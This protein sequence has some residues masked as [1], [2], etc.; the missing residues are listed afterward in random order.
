[1]PK[2]RK[3][4]KIKTKVSQ[5]TAPTS[6]ESIIS[7]MELSNFMN[8]VVGILGEI[9]ENQKVL[10]DLTLRDEVK[11]L[12]DKTSDEK[13][14]KKD[15]KKDDPDPDP[16]PD[17]ELSKLRK[18]F[19]DSFD[20]VRNFLSPGGL[21]KSFGLVSG[22]PIFML[23]GEKFDGLMDYYQ[24][25]KEEE[26]KKQEE[27]L[28]RLEREKH[29]DYQ[30]EQ[31]R[32]EELKLQEDT[33]KILEDIRDKEDSKTKKED[34]KKGVL[35]WLKTPLS[36]F[37]ALLPA[38]I[39]KAFAGIKGLGGL[40]GKGG[41]ALAGGVAA[42][43]GGVAAGAAKGAKG[44]GGL[45]KGGARLLGKAALPLTLALGAID[46]AKGFGNAFEI[47]GREGIVAKIQGGLS[48][49][50]SGF[51]FGLIDAKT[52]SKAIDWLVVKVKDIFFA[53]LN[54]IKDLWKGEKPIIDIV[55]E[56]YDKM[57]YGLIGKDTIKNMIIWVK[58]KVVNIAKDI[59]KI[60]MSI[61]TMDNLKKTYSFLVDKI[62]QILQ[63]PINW[64]K[65]AWEHEKASILAIYRPLEKISLKII[66]GIK[67]IFD[68]ITDAITTIINKIVTS[69]TEKL[70]YLKGKIDGLMNLISNPLDT[71]KS[72]FTTSDYL[73]DVDHVDSPVNDIETT[74]RDS[75][76]LNKIDHEKEKE[77]Q[78]QLKKERELS[79]KNKNNNNNNNVISS[80]VNN[81]IIPNLDLSTRND[82]PSWGLAF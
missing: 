39:V 4:K 63:Y 77:R 19:Q 55:S 26:L 60:T 62:K 9:S 22:S 67:N 64:L 21:L 6:N 27:E 28:K 11:K 75:K 57:T 61:F 29:D 42:G 81:N 80:T 35:E 44:V 66:D 14:P 23:I 71:I 43:A 73:F 18:I 15:P 54:L 34:D 38:K 40:I 68:K 7:P 47:T 20:S 65:E 52:V 74:K 82:D 59:A 48:E 3:I 5:S 17:P 25:L 2:N 8:G 50:I 13:K 58:E 53:P 79:E 78:I 31:E 76:A 10:K 72:F 16:D 37:A 45:L 1:M 49:A 36:I 56:Y 12:K 46:F 30:K 51:T 33:N 41:G 24:D 69:F 32:E 70:D